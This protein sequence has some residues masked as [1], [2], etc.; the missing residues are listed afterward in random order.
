MIQ[1]ASN[2]AVQSGQVGFAPMRAPEQPSNRLIAALPLYLQ[3][4]ESL[5]ERIESGELGPGDR[6]PPERELSE[7]LEVNRMTVRR[8]LR[9]LENRGLL[10]RRQGHG[11]FIAEPKI[12]R[13]A[14]RLT[15]F[16]VGMRQRGLQPGARIVSLELRPA[17]AS[18]SNLLELPVSAAVY[19]ILRLRS[20]NQEPVLLERYTIP[21]GSFPGLDRY[22][23]ESRSLYEVFHTEY[24]VAI[25]RARQSLEPVIA[26]EFE[27]DLLGVP[28]GAPLMLEWRLS[29][30][31]AGLP[32]EHGKDLYRGDRF[33]FVTETASPEAYD[34]AEPWT[35]SALGSSPSPAASAS[36]QPRPNQRGGSS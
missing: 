28:P 6:L 1:S 11:T 36:D 23:L 2:S 20:L 33:R 29:F 13:Q 14:S 19:S 7:M 35:P 16:T 27:A 24:G 26:T 8:A 22:D 12:E 18:V 4:A 10:L 32:I 31:A 30:D 34:G 5:L 21:F 3:I 9:L 17:E 25:A 15:S